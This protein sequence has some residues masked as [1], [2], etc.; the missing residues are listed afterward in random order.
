MAK[1]NSAKR[2]PFRVDV[3]DDMGNLMLGRVII[4]SPQTFGIS[5]EMR[6]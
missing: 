4:P 5:S 6:G 3:R 2:A 1:D